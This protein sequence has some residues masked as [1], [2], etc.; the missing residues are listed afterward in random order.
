MRV[1]VW[2]TLDA[3]NPQTGLRDRGNGGNPLT[4]SVAMHTDKIREDRLRRKL[5]T[6]GYRLRKTPVR[7]WLRQVYGPG[8]MITDTSR[9]TVVFGCI[10][11]EY[12][13]SLEEAEEY[14]VY[15]AT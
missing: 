15:L 4:G 14:A 5:T 10:H 8:Y 7:S 11:H 9:N 2:V 13:G 1:T 12:S 3:G 6:L